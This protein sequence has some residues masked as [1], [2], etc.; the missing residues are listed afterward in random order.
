MAVEVLSAINRETIDRFGLSIPGLPTPPPV[1]VFGGVEL[2]SDTESVEVT[3]SFATAAILELKAEILADLLKKDQ[4]GQAHLF[5]NRLAVR[6]WFGRLVEDGGIEGLEYLQG[7]ITKSRREDKKLRFTPPHLADADHP[8]VIYLMKRKNRGLG[9]QNEL[10][11]MAGV[12]ML[13]RPAIRRFTRSENVIYNVT[14]RDMDHIAT[15]LVK[16]DE[17]GFDEEQFE[18]LKEIDKTFKYARGAAMKKITEICSVGRRPLV[19]YVEGGRSYGGFLK[20]SSAEFAWLFPRDDSAIVV[21]YR[22]YGAREF[23]PPGKD[24]KVLRKGLL[25]YSGEPK[26]VLRM[27]VGE[28]YPSREIWQVWRKRTA[29]AIE[30]AGGKKVELNPMEWVMANIANLDPDYVNP[31]DLPFYSS[32]MAR[33]APE[34]NRIP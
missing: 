18:K 11:F 25:P 19:V 17:Y 10:F 23:N 5:L 2:Q 20:K 4:M 12:N 15:L 14:P 31:E 13:R 30:M 1:R 7:A 21:P 6:T 27:R 16:K 32:L 22:I 24:P 29:E 34:R 3:N 28:H 26:Q 9:L 8:S 33:F